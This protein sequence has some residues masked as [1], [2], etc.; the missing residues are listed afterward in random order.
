MPVVVW[1]SQTRPGSDKL[2]FCSHST[3]VQTKDGQPSILC[4]Y[5]NAGELEMSS[6]SVSWMQRNRFDEMLAA[7]NHISQLCSFLDL[8]SWAYLRFAT[9]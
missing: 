5:L 2:H 9:I 3:Q 7:F 6:S 4:L 8:F 1:G